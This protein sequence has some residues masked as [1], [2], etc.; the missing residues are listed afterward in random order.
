MSLVT[1]STPTKGA[2]FTTVSFPIINPRCRFR[3]VRS[4]TILG[5]VKSENLE[6]RQGKGRMVYKIIPKQAERMGVAGS[7]TKPLCC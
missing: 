7:R 4:D 3:K 2:T 5:V 1:S 6:E